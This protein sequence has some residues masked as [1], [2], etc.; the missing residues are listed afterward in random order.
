MNLR[1]VIYFTVKIQLDFV[2]ISETL[3]DSLG[4]LTS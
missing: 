3:H 4:G 1:L 2:K